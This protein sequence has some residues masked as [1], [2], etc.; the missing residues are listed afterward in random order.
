MSEEEHHEDMEEDLRGML[1]PFVDVSVLKKDRMLRIVMSPKEGFE[2]R[3]SIFKPLSLEIRSHEAQSPVHPDMTTKEKAKARKKQR[4]I[5]NDI[6][7]IA[8]TKFAGYL[9]PAAIIDFEELVTTVKN[10]YRAVEIFSYLCQANSPYH[11]NF[12]FGYLME[13]VRKSCRPGNLDAVPHFSTYLEVAGFPKTGYIIR[14]YIT[15]ELSEATLDP[16]SAMIE[17][18]LREIFSSYATIYLSSMDMPEEDIRESWYIIDRVCHIPEYKY[19]PSVYDEDPVLDALKSFSDPE[20]SALIE[21]V[22]RAPT[23]EAP[24]PP[25]EVPPTVPEEKGLS[26]EGESKEEILKRLKD[27]LGKM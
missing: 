14:E 16:L 15:E 19:F 23:E 3:F 11:C 5:Y 2:D 9:K 4:E 20:L 26:K 13:L 6:L 21:S 27:Y 10:R 22:I 1:P 18:G 8:S 7:R 24:S 17:H 25:P 12:L